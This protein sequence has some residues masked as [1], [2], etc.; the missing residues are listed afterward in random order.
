MND[1]KI[2]IKEVERMKE[3]MRRQ[4]IMNRLLSETPEFNKQA[5]LFKTWLALGSVPA[6]VQC[7]VCG[8]GHLSFS[9]GHGDVEG[10]L[11]LVGHMVE[12]HSQE[13][14]RVHR[15]MKQEHPELEMIPLPK[16]EGETE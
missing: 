3:N 1:E 10:A 5:R 14:K 16:T 15:K 8:V 2:P 6:N 12:N 13:T 7:P 11:A 4:K 9:C